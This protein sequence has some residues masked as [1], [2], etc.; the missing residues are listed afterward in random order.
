MPANLTQNNGKTEMF[1]TGQRPWYGLGTKLENPAT[2]QEAIIAASMD[3]NIE[4]IPVQT[5]TGIQIKDQ[6]AIVRSDN[7][8]P[9]GIVGKQ[10][11]ML[12]NVEAFDFFDSV[13][14][15][16]KA[17]YHTA[18]T[19]AGGKRI[20][21]L[22]KLPKPMIIAKKDEVEKFILLTAAHDGK[23]SLKMLKTPVRVVCQNT[24]NMALKNFDENISIRHTK[25]M[26]EKVTAAQ[27]AFSIME[28]NYNQFEAASN[29]LASIQIDG[30]IFLTFLNNVFPIDKKAGKVTV[31]HTKEKKEKVTELFE[32]GK[33]NNE[34]K[35]KRTL[36][37]AVNAVAE[38]GDHF[39]KTK[40]HSPET[41]LHSTWFGT[42]TDIKQKAWD[43]AIKLTK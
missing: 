5:T 38:Y 2:S 18:G 25:N 40:H 29:M 9:L 13:V 28:E 41:K 22:A 8:Y 16:K 15:S 4:K 10:Y 42:S 1:Y 32:N 11:K 14:G 26:S 37:T 21:I 6:F 34:P 12:Q 30:K 3:W 27:K 35:T 33:G 23:G 17:I 43:M 36:W 24:L 31:E 39:Q 7:S 20:W 19:L